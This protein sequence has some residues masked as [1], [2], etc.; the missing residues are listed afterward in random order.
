MKAPT[1]GQQLAAVPGRKST[2]L[3]LRLALHCPTKDSASAPP[4]SSQRVLQ[5]ARHCRGTVLILGAV[6]PYE[7]SA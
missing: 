6:N 3:R 4:S 5:G 2:R 7:T 1:L